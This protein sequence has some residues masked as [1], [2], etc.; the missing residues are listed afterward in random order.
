[1]EDAFHLIRPGQCMHDA[2]C[3]EHRRASKHS[4]GRARFVVVG[5]V[6]VVAVAVAIVVVCC[7]W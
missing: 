7:R 1:M 2:W 3:Q 6:G 5:I 4:M